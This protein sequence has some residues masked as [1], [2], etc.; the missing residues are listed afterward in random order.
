MIHTRA[1][2]ANAA[3]YRKLSRASIIYTND[4]CKPFPDLQ[5]PGQLSLMSRELSVDGSERNLK[6]WN[7]MLVSS[8]LNI[9]IYT[10]IIQI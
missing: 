7:V 10:D 9:I 8:H 6:W 1:Q 4:G 3:S 5:I 2:Q